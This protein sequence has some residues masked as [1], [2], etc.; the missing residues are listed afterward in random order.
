[1]S[2]QQEVGKNM[3]SEIAI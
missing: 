1:L 2:F 3:A